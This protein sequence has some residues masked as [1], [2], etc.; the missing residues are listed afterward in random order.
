MLLKVRDR[1]QLNMILAGVQGNF[2]TIKTINKLS[3]DLLLSSDEEKSVCYKQNG[4]SATWKTE[5]DTGA[6]I[7]INETANGVIIE[8]LKKLDEQ[9]KL[10][11][12][13][14]P[15]WERFCEAKE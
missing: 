10:T 15:L 12:E 4:V 7:E 8:Q 14:L 13:L 9:K 5:N 3:E 6:D 1:I 11:V 2:G